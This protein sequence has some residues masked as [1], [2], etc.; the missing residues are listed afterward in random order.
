MNEYTVKIGPATKPRPRHQRAPSSMA[1][2]NQALVHPKSRLSPLGGSKHHSLPSKR[3]HVLFCNPVCTCKEEEDTHPS[4]RTGE[5][6]A[7]AYKAARG[8]SP[9]KASRRRRESP[10]VF[11]LAAIPLAVEVLPVAHGLNTATIPVPRKHPTF[12]TRAETRHTGRESHQI[13]Q[14]P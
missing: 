13:S 12:P 9:H 14:E 2:L 5:S 11:E 1:R 8:S 6:E 10:P 7:A 3:T 4:L